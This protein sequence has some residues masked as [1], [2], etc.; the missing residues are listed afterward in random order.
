MYISPSDGLIDPPTHTTEERGERRGT[1]NACAWDGSTESAKGRG[2][3][4]KGENLHAAQNKISVHLI[5]V[6]E[7]ISFTVFEAIFKV[8]MRSQ[9]SS[10]NARKALPGPRSVGC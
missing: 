7:L 1:K 2:R 6:Q 4:S 9:Q 5:E 8:S 3:G 10:L